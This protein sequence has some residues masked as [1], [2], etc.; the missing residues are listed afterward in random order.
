MRKFYPYKLFTLAALLLV[1]NGCEQVV[2]VQGTVVDIRSQRLPGVAVTA[3]NEHSTINDLRYQALASATGEYTLLCPPGEWDLRFEKTG[4]TTAHYSL[5]IPEEQASLAR[6]AQIET[7]EV[8]LWPLPTGKGIYLF[9]NYRYREIDTAIPKRYRAIAPPAPVVGIKIIPD[10]VTYETM[11]LLV[12]YKIPGYNIQLYRLAPIEAAPAAAFSADGTARPTF[13]EQL[14]CPADA[15]PLST[16]PIDEPE[17]ILLE[18]RPRKPLEPGI[19]AFHWGGLD[20]FDQPVEMGNRVFTFRIDAPPEA[21]E[22][23]DE[24]SDTQ[25]D[26][27]ESAAE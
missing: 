3:V 12:G 7:S 15:I 23:T 8:L 4:Y 5:T 16:V 11:P 22:P 27:A 13:S 1:C 9:E 24:A 21:L 19:Y 10:C 20:G 2:K 26:E 14:Y 25:D 17:R 18:I 6:S